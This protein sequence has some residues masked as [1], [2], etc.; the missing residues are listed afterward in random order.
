MTEV[1]DVA[2]VNIIKAIIGATD[3][4][5]IPN[6]TT[7]RLLQNIVSSYECSGFDGSAVDQ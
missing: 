2:L 3:T 5:K 6:Q 1:R 4:Q 7:N